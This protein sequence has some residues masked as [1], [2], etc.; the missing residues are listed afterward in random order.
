MTGRTSECKKAQVY[1]H[2]PTATTASVGMMAAYLPM[3]SGCGGKGGKSFK[4]SFQ[5]V[6]TQ[7]PNSPSNT[8]VFSIFEASDSVTNLKVV[9]DRFGDEVGHLEEQTWK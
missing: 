5:V 9:G 1:T 2:I 3:R 7:A 8:C 6:N 4:M